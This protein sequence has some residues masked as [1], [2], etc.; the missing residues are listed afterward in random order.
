MSVDDYKV[1]DNVLSADP[2]DKLNVEV[3]K[4]KGVLLN[5]IFDPDNRRLDLDYAYCGQIKGPIPCVHEPVSE[6]LFTWT[7][8]T[9]I[10]NK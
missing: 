7:I 9:K 5:L 8:P 6:N 4:G 10:L 1:Y 2:G 3:F